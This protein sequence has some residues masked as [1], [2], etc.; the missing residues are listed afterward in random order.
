[1]SA[2]RFKADEDDSQTLLIIHIFVALYHF[3]RCGTK[4]FTLSTVVIRSSDEDQ[5]WLKQ[6]VYMLVSAAEVEVS[7][8][9]KKT[10]STHRPTTTTNDSVRESGLLFY[11]V[12]IGMQV[13]L[14]V[15]IFFLN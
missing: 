10:D 15:S 11:Q 9:W 4:K 5:N 14:P 13:S 1:M 6:A 3:T 7:G 2:L 12:Y 8:D